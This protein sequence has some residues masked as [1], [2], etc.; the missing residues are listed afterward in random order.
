M[1]S[2]ALQ[3]LVKKIFSDEETRLQF[4]S[5]PDSILDQFAITEQEKKAI[6]SIHAKLGTVASN[7][8]QLEAVLDSRIIWHAPTP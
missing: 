3:E 7:S 4:A 6:L 5:N 2:K 1:K 8:Q